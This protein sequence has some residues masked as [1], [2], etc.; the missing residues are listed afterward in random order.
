VS[1]K[2]LTAEEIESL[3]EQ[4]ILRFGGVIGV[5]NRS[6]LESAAGDQKWLLEGRNFIRHSKKKRR[7]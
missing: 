6:L 5:L 3:H 2:Y 7:L 4:I 1:I